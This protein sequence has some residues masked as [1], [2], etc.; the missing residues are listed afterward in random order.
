MDYIS[1]N[2]KV[3]LEKEGDAEP[4]LIRCKPYPAKWLNHKRKEKWANKNRLKKCAR[5]MDEQGITGKDKYRYAIWA[6]YT[7]YE[8]AYIAKLVKTKGYKKKSK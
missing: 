3:L 5:M 8:A 2:V 7:G 1:E 4:W 6:G